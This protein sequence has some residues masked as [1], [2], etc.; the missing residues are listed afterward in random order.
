MR[1]RKGKRL[2]GKRGARAHRGGRNQASMATST[3]DSD[4]WNHTVWRRFD[5]IERGETERAS[6]GFYRRPCLW[7]GLGFW[8]R[9]RSTYGSGSSHVHPGLLA[10]G[11]G[12]TRG[13]GLSASVRSK[14]HTGSGFGRIWAGLAISSW[15]DLVPG[16]FFLFSLFLSLFYFLIS[17]LFN[18]FCIYVSIW[19]KQTS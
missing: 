7:R 12:M 11:G 1:Q 6:R 2:G 14:G 8:D 3:T 17:G 15:A 16:A 18:I 9:I 4:E 10:G 13:A 5:G 19:F